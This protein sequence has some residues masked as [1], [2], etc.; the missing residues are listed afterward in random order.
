MR[1]K[2][3]RTRLRSATVQRTVSDREAQAGLVLEPQDAAALDSSSEDE[4]GGGGADVLQL[5]S[6]TST[7]RARLSAMPLEDLMHG[8]SA[9]S[10][11]RQ[12]RAQPLVTA[13]HR[14]ASVGRSQ[15]PESGPR[16]GRA[17]GSARS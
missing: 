6:P 9:C 12:S 5:L 1:D 15:L 8:A 17:L 3:V 14:V 7:T 2:E 13:R 10:R 11:E 4:G 16:G